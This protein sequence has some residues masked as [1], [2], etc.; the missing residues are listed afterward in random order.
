MYYF[1]HVSL[2]HCLSK[3]LYPENLSHKNN[4][5]FASTFWSLCKEQC[6]KIQQQKKQT[7]LW[8]GPFALIYDIIVLI[9]KQHKE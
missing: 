7:H 2:L 4:H 8:K 5:C 3:S 1:R 6:I 9:W